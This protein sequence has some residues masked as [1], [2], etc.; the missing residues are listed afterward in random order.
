M[1]L[2]EQAAPSIS[3]ESSSSNN[4]NDSSN[5]K[6]SIAPPEIYLS[7]AKGLNK[8]EEESQKALEE[9]AATLKKTKAAI[10]EQAGTVLTNIK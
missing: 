3:G 8:L 9:A 2:Q 1:L 5:K 7:L 10:K 6:V 4:N